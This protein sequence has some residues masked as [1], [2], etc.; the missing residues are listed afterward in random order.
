MITLDLRT[1]HLTIDELF[2]AAASEAVHVIA[3]DGTIFVLE[4]A[5]EFEREVAQ[6]GQSKPFMAFLAERSKETGGIS[7]E[8]AIKRLDRTETQTEEPE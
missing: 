8:D 6:F 7:L 1:E 2:Q 3:K 4:P 5:D